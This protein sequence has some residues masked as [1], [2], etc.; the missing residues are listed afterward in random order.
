MVN[1]CH[2]RS[3]HVSMYARPRTGMY[4][5]LYV[6]VFIWLVVFLCTHVYMYFYKC[7]VCMH[8]LAMRRDQGPQVTMIRLAMHATFLGVFISSS[9]GITWTGTEYLAAGHRICVNGQC[10]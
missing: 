5:C 4:V 7:H 8:M 6:Y 9:L 2:V 1:V 10:T 3:R